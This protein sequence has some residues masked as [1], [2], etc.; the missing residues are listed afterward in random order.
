M[1]NH[2]FNKALFKTLLHAKSRANSYCEQY[3]DEFKV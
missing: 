1:N 2:S 3:K